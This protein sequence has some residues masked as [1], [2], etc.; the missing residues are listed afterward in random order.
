MFLVQANTHVFPGGVLDEADFSPQ[1]LH[2]FGDLQHHTDMNPFA[3]IL[4]LK[5]SS[6][7][8]LPLYSTVPGDV[9]SLPGEIAFRICAIRELFEEAGVML[10]RDIASIK[11][12]LE[13]LPGSFKP[14]VKFLSASIREQWRERVHS[15]A[16]EF[17]TMCR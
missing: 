4:N 6:A 15:N 12:M 14:T 17:T 1:W 11:T 7:P 5:D 10:A 3:S 8:Q 2:V 9:D 16:R 13:L